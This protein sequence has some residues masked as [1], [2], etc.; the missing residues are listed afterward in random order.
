MSSMWGKNI[1]IS[2][3]GESHGKAIG[4]VIDGI[5]PGISLDMKKI[6][7]ELQ[8]RAPGKSDFSTP[9]QEKDEVEI[10]SGYFNEKTTGTSICAIIYNKDQKS[11]DYEKTKSIM[12]PSHGDYTGY[13]KYKGFNDYRGGGHFSGRITASIVFAGAIAKQIL[14]TKNIFIGSHIKGIGN[15]EDDSFDYVDISKD[16]LQKLAKESFPVLNDSK[17]ED[18][19][20][21]IL[22]VKKE[23]NSIGGIIETGI[24]NVPTGIG[25]PFF[26]SIESK[27]SQLLF[28]IPGIKGVEFGEGFKMSLMTGEN[29]N[30]EFY[31][32]DEQVKTHT[33]HNGGI[34]GGISSG[35]PIVFK[36][37]CKPTP[38][39]GKIQ[40]SIN[41]ETMKNSKIQIEGRHDPCI[42]PRVIPVVEAMAALAILDLM[43]EDHV[44]RI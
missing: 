11:K 13:I 33:N 36:V 6:K 40:R 16:L 39:I 19:K 12:R 5:F 17:R 9:R 29:G 41:I 7:E 27:L 31:I 38:S 44:W 14:N 20:N 35:M 42:V 32:K 23:S 8:R 34:L 15:V 1:K 4:V 30:D 18:M 37:A 3:F 2:I 21:L 25:S 24:I 26:D 22:N 28:S 43:M 10:L